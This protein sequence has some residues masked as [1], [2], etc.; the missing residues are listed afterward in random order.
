METQK[1]ERQG[2]FEQLSLYRS[3]KLKTEAD[4]QEH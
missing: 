1:W 4:K 2:K 3:G